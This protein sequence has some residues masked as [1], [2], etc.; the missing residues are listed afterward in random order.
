MTAI[1][2][3]KFQGK[4]PILSDRELPDNFAV[5]TN[6]VKLHSG[7]IRGLRNL[8]A[9]EDFS[10]AAIVTA[11]RVVDKSTSTTYWV[12]FTVDDVDFARSPLANDA[13]NRVYWT[14]PDDVPRY[15]TLARV[16][17]ADPGLRLGVPEP[18]TAPTVTPDGMGSATENETR[19]YVYTFVTA[20]GEEG[21]P[22]PPTLAVGKPDDS[23]DLSDIDASVPDDTERDMDK[24]YIYR[25]AVGSSGLADFFFV[26]EIDYGQ[27]TYSDTKSNLEVASN[28]T[29]KSVL[30]HPPPSNLHGLLIHPNGFGV[31]FS[32]NSLYFSEPYRL[33]AW[34]SKY[35]ISV[36]YPIVG[37]GIY[38]QT[39]VVMT[40]AYPYIATGTRPDTMTLVK[41]RLAE[42]CLSK[43]S[44]VSALQGV[45]YASKNGLVLVNSSGMD[46]IT[47]NTISNEEWGPFYQPAAV[48]A[49]K[50]Q[51]YYIA[52]ISSTT[53]FIIDLAASTP[54]IVD[55]DAITDVDN[56]VADDLTGNILLFSNNI[57]YLWD[58]N[59]QP[60]TSWLWRSKV[61]ES[62]GPLNFG[63]GILHAKPVSNPATESVT[64]KMFAGVYDQ[65]N[66][67]MIQKYNQVVKAGEMFR[68]PSGYKATEWQ[69]ELSGNMNVMSLELGET[70]EDLKSA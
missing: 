33:H 9:L 8:L 5:D 31:G 62:P 22:S 50:Y 2:L 48:K 30:W 44:I 60:R 1:K 24:V 45:L 17:T 20:Y 14:R 15:N 67:Q 40:D 11:F 34:P 27:T 23:W 64:L 54:Y 6:N 41:M 61:F 21:P 39:V 37:L 63:C 29:L 18:T 52:Y 55:I 43:R 4:L 69:F 68:L 58:D 70:P 35:V 47:R 32:G 51:T 36:E 10:P 57:S 13:F 42:P 26:D 56:I 3:H 49:A 66:F 19:S 38:G 53:G 12:P 28:D 25:T 46:V 65:N 7:E 16:I 59:A